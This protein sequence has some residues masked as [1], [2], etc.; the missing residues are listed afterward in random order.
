MDITRQK[1]LI[2]ISGLA[3]LCW[4]GT[5]VAQG[6]TPA[7]TDSSVI[8]ADGTAFVTRVVPVPTTI[9]PEARKWLA[10]PVSDAALPGVARD[11][12]HEDQRVAGRCGGSLSQALS[13][14][15]G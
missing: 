15:F 8:G 7:K 13:G 4:S 12:T 6:T 5:C 10:R 2:G 3:I 14:E 9:S 1:R 11:P